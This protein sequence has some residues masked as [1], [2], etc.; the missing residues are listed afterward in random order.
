MIRGL[1]FFILVYSF[2]AAYGKNV[3]L[4]IFEL[5]RVA[6]EHSLLASQKSYPALRAQKQPWDVAEHGLV[7]RGEKDLDGIQAV[8]SLLAERDGTYPLIIDR[9]LNVVIDHRLPD[10]T[11]SKTDPY[12]GNHRG[13]LQ[14]LTTVLGES[15]EVVFAGQLRVNGGRVINIIDQS[16]TFYFFPEDFGF[17][18]VD[19]VPLLIEQN[20]KRL[21]LAVDYL[22]ALEILASTT[23][24]MNFVKRYQHYPEQ[25]RNEGHV[26]AQ[27]AAEFERFC[28]SNKN[29]WAKY[30]AIERQLRALMPIGT[31]S[32][33]N[34]YLR[35]NLPG[36][37]VQKYENIQ[38]WNMILSEG[39]IDVM[40]L[41]NMLN[42]KSPQG[43]LFNNFLKSL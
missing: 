6:S 8:K 3:C 21:D 18:G 15:P 42:P 11:V 5:E 28:R 17:R 12:V 36:T 20:Q 13:L 39:I 43:L 14:K 24:V 1:L 23:E 32:E 27:R 19:K 26:K 41:P 40:A 31:K 2:D 29:C 38:F 33:I 34:E 22:K 4:Q 10:I 37:I 35:D 30:K 16:G 7:I 9:Q 25:D